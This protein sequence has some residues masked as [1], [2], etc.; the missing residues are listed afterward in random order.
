M[1]SVLLT[2]MHVGEQFVAI[3]DICQTFIKCKEVYIL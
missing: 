3:L 1:N 2:E